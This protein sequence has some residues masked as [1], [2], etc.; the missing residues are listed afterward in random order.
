[1]MACAIV[2]AVEPNPPVWP[3]TV[4]VVDPSDGTA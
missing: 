1:M 3:N 4:L 2:I